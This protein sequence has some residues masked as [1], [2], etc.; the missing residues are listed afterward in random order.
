MDDT[1]GAAEQPGLAPSVPGVS[2]V[3][4]GLCTSVLQCSAV[5]WEFGDGVGGKAALHLDPDNSTLAVAEGIGQ[6]YQRKDSV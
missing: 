3:V 6:D 1:S 4:S 2:D 5:N